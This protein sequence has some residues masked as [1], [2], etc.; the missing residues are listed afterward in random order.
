MKL[1][2]NRQKFLQKYW[3][4][5]HWIYH[6][7]DTD[8]INIHSVNALYLVFDKVDGYIKE[9]GGNKYLTLVSNNKNKEV[10]KIHRTM[11]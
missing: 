9:S 11:E 5:F 6:N 1:T 10:L 4:L 7:K 2:K 3:N 8:Y